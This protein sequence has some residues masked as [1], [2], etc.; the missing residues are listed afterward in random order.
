MRGNVVL[1]LDLSLTGLGMCA[2]P[3]DWDLDWT[4]VRTKVRGTKREKHE[5]A[6]AHWSRLEQLA[7]DVRVFA[8]LVG[9]THVWAEGGIT[10]IGTGASL[11]ALGELRSAV[12]LELKRECGLI[13]ETAH[14]STIRSFFLGKLPPRDRKE[15]TC[16]T[17][18]SIAADVWANKSN[19]EC[20]AFVVANWGLSEL[21]AP[22][23]AA[24]PPDKKKRS[25]RAA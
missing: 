4:R 16:A 23:I 24:P 19:D 10:K 11:V 22:C 17:L 20:D 14:Q 9:A 25:R 13:V 3:L 8:V 2:V 1:G 18:R 7:I 6:A 15:V 12:C 21:A 5:S